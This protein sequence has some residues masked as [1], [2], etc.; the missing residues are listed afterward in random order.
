VTPEHR[1]RTASSLISRLTAYGSADMLNWIVN[2]KKI[3]PH[4]PVIDKLKREDGTFSRKDFK[5]EQERN[6]YLPRWRQSAHPRSR[7]P[8]P[9]VTA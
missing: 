3:A 7:A 9:G 5:F 1:T 8:L 2:E 4:I 6:I